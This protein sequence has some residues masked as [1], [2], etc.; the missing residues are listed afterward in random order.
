MVLQR[1]APEFH[2]ANY[3]AEDF[4]RHLSLRARSEAL[5]AR[6]IGARTCRSDGVAETFPLVHCREDDAGTP[7]IAGSLARRLPAGNESTSTGL[8]TDY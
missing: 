8:G 6:A 5:E 1:V 3:L 2:S 7:G 4:A